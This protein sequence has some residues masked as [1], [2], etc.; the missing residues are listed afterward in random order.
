MT[1]GFGGWLRSRFS[2]VDE[3]GEP[4]TDIF[5]M[6]IRRKVRSMLEGVRGPVL[7]AG[8]GS[9]LLLDP[10][11]S[12]CAKSSVVL[13]LDGDELRKGRLRYGGEGEFVQGDMLQLPFVD[14]CF[15]A[16]IC[17]GTFYNF[18]DTKLVSAAVGELARV[19]VPG[20]SVFVE[21]RNAENPLVAAAF[22][23]AGAYDPSLDGLP[24]RAYS[25]ADVV[26]IVESVGLRVETV[27]SFG[28]RFRFSALAYIYHTIK[29][30]GR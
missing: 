6:A 26:R 23:T 21:F 5:R 9:G 24:L 13:D 19:T 15:A 27:T 12:T 4:T 28:P 10:G 18:P 22:R 2:T 11:V 20:G 3:R 17:I 16:S 30:G 25:R 29:A 14:E 8:G 7:D 1:A